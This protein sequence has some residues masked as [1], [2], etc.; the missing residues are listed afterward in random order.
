MAEQDPIAKSDGNLSRDSADK[1]NRS[2]VFDA[3]GLLL[4]WLALLAIPGLMPIYP[5]NDD[6]LYARSVEIWQREGKLVWVS[7]NG[8]LPAAALWLIVVATAA[9]KVFGFSFALLAAVNL[10]HA[11]LGLVALFVLARRLGTRVSRPG[12]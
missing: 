2:F 8:Q 11:W 10:T 5:T 4:L 12:F 6:F 7:H 3:V 1:R 9:V